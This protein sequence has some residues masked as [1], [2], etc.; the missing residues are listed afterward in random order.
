LEFASFASRLLLP[1]PARLGQVASLQMAQQFTVSK[2][3]AGTP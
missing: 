1:T 3:T 2:R